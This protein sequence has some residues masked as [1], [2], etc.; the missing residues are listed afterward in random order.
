M[1]G[2]P[3]TSFGFSLGYDQVINLFPCPLRCFLPGLAAVHTP[4][5]VVDGVGRVSDQDVF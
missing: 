5:V 1:V 2:V 4:H 3:L